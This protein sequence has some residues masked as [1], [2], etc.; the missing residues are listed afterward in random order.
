MA[1]TRTLGAVQGLRALA[2]ILVVLHH[3]NLGVPGGF[4]G[5]D[6]FFVISGFVITRLL[7]LQADD[8]SL[9]LADFYVRRARRILPALTLMVFVVLIASVIVL[10]PYWPLPATIETGKWALVG[11][12][13]ISI[14]RTHFDYFT[15]HTYNALLHT[16]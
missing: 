14:L 8:R 10:S 13:N 1:P 4:L 6:V 11:A 3:A 12:S 2:I 16:W 9:S 5:V 15:P 7:L